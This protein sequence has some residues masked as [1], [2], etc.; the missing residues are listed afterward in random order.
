[1]D[2]NQ[3][4]VTLYTPG[5]TYR[6][7]IDMANNAIRTIDIFNAANIYWKDPAERSFN[8][9]LLVNNASISLSGNARLGEFA[10]LQVKLADI[11]FFHDSL[12]NLSDSME[13]R[14][15]A[16]LMQK[17]G[18]N[19][20]QVNIITHTRGDSFFYISGTFYGLFKSK[21]NCRY[22]PITRVNVIEVIRGN[23][24]WQKR[25]IPIEGGFIGIGTEHIE[26]CTFSEPASHT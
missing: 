22:I 14:R 11:I 20:S 25:T 18:E 4:K 19:T 8:D 21:S 12:E 13:K 15:A 16:Y 7:Y 9:A 2:K 1:M 10:K 6:G 3:R 26:A 23:D 5:K 17:T 24:K